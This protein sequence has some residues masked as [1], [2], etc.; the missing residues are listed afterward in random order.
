MLIPAVFPAIVSGQYL[1]NLSA[2]KNDPL[3]STYAAPVQRSDYKLDQAYRMMWYDQ[4]RNIEFVSKDGGNI[5]AG[6]AMNGEVR[7]RLNEYFGEAEVTT[8]YPDLVEF[9]FY[10]FE[11]LR[12]E[13]QFAVYSS[14][15]ALLTYTIINE[16]RHTAYLSFLPYYSE[17]GPVGNPSVEGNSFV[18]HL[19]KKRDGWMK[20]HD[21]PYA[22]DLKSVFA[23]NRQPDYFGGY[24]TFPHQE[25]TEKRMLSGKINGDGSY[26]V[27]QKNLIIEPEDTV[28][29]RLARVIDR[30]P[31]ETGQLI[32]AARQ[33]MDV[34]FDELVQENRRL[35]SNI[36]RIS[37]SN[38]DHEAVY[39]H[40][41]NLMRQCMMP[42]EGECSYNYYIFSR[43]P[44]WGWGYGGQVFH[45]SLVMLAY[46]YMDP[47]SA[48]NSQRV[49]MERQWPSGYI[50]YRTGPYLNEQIERDGEYTSSAPWY[51]WQ[52]LEIFKIT[53]DDSFLKEAYRSGK[54]F[55]EYFVSNRD[56]DGDGLCEWGAH[57]VLECVRDA[58]V[59]VW[60]QVGW[61]SN[62]E[63]PD[64]NA[65][66]VSEANALA[67]MAAILGKPAEAD[68]FRKDAETRTG[69]INEKLWDATDGFYYN[70]NMID[71]SF[72]YDHP[73]DL[74][75]KEIIGFL[76][77]WAGVADSSKA[78]V[79]MQSLLNE[80]E[81]WRNYGVP[82]LSASHPYYNPIGYWNG[83][84][85]VQWQYLLFRGLLDYGYT[86]EARELA[87]R[88]LDNMAYH[89]KKDHV[90]W[91]FYSADDRQAG[92][93]QTYIW[94]GIA[95]RF[96]IDLDRL[97]RTAE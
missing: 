49:Y 76:P 31:A 60:D 65:M 23:M 20:N 86:G 21:I 17:D 39:W 57:A 83:P 93:N 63:G 36:P 4:E 19:H 38:P 47:E 50:N 15:Q 73:G 85:W 61:P 41:F 3:F 9:R 6:F 28:V 64:V 55:Y 92:W 8:S 52:N 22:E 69:L 79:L 40:S 30:Q 51:N 10:P 29:V 59:A 13:G 71:G 95:A 33:T 87:H 68:R 89:L 62:F 78:A 45:E 24:E 32:A 25:I 35:F 82:T 72:T 34:N 48:M 66:L 7:Y 56:K 97:N 84:V 70:I 88:V 2:K 77:L 46:A 53:E 67:E 11:H 80:D 91:E 90:F 75:I 16:G 54:A 5:G 96:L 43:E 18:W 94:A 44:K 27:F 14:T 1:S 81:F 37:F 74:K 26:L 42:P 58:R 12:T